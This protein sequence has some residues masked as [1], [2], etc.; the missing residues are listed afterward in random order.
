MEQ[1]VMHS[2]S[3]LMKYRFLIKQLSINYVSKLQTL[4]L[5]KI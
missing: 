2:S 5:R 3:G 1:H 4:F